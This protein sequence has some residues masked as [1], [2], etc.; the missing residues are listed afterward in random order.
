MKAKIAELM[1]VLLLVLLVTAAVGCK[2]PDEHK[3]GPGSAT[4]QAPDESADEAPEG[5]PS[6]QPESSPE[7]SATTDGTK[8]L[9]D[10]PPD[11]LKQAT[12]AGGCFWCMESAFDH[13]PGVVQAISG[14]T[15][16]DV[17]HPKYH[18]VGSGTTGHAESVRIYYDPKKTSYEKLLDVFWH[19]IDPTDSGGQFV[20][21]GSQYRPAIFYHDEQQKKLAEK[22]KADLE[23]NGPFKKPIV[24]PI[25][26]AKTFWKAEEYHQDFWKK[27][28][29]HYHRYRRGSGRDQ[30]IEKTWG[31]TG[32]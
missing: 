9:P 19:Q 27:N 14:Y 23:K 10:N 18:Q 30:F 28:P 25:E 20:D 31:K 8:A 11:G 22:S 1:S 21:R 2:T 24:V 13:V 16:G 15:G 4:A 26:P 17:A 5:A 12:F 32:H 7:T 3:S 6:S 29:G